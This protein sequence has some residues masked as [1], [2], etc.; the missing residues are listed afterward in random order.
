[1][2]IISRDER[3][4]QRGIKKFIN[5]FKYP[6]SGLRYAYKNE[7]NLAVDI[8]M[9]VIVIVLGVLL[10]ISVVE[11]AI[12]TITVGLVISLELVNTSIEAV[13]DLV[14]QEYHPLAKVA[15]DTSAS[16]VLILAIVSIIEGIIIFLPK[17]IELF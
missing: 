12:L 6:F 15:K 7:Q 13:V 5:S 17:I 11:W 14:T 4:N 2:S 9:A 1:M 16:A 8:G 10:N 3:K